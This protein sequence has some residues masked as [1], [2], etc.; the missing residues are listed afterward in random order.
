[1]VTTNA[2]QVSSGKIVCFYISKHI[3]KYVPWVRNED[4]VY[5]ILISFELEIYVPPLMMRIVIAPKTLK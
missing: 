1:M 5:L 3:R 2:V 4:I